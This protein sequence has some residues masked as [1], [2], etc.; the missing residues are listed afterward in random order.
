M[1][2]GSIETEIY[3]SMAGRERATAAKWIYV[4]KN[5]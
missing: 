4:K 5:I 1:F 3:G 2:M